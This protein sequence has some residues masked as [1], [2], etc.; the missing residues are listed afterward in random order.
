[1]QHSDRQA[2]KELQSMITQPS[3]KGRA[4]HIANMHYDRVQTVYA[5]IS[6]LD[7]SFHL[8]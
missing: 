5:F 8:V 7:M 2:E 1:M 6:I 3:E 4:H